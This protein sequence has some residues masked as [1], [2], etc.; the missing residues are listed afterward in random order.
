MDLFNGISSLKSLHWFYIGCDSS[1][2]GIISKTTG[3]GSIGK[4]IDSAIHKSL[5]K[6][7]VNLLKF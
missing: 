1:V 7:M 4:V 5:D 3:N 6:A 2:M